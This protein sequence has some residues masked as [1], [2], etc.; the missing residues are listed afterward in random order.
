MNT[1][2]T[3]GYRRPGVRRGPTWW[4]ASVARQ[5]CPLRGQPGDAQGLESEG[6]WADCSRKA[7]AWR[8]LTRGERR[9]IDGCLRTASGRVIKGLKADDGESWSGLSERSLCGQQTRPENFSAFLLHWW[10]QSSLRF[11]N[12]M[13]DT[14]LG[15]ADSG[16]ILFSNTVRE[17]VYALSMECS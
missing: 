12:Q 7:E 1:G 14:E 17:S 2:T 9:E 10:E 8:E 16:L 6:H 15:E 5:L 13:T 4:A 3:Y 11:E